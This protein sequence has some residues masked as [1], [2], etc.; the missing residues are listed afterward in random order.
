MEY[1]EFLKNK[2]PNEIDR[3]DLNVDDIH[4]A[5]FPFQQDC[6]KYL[7][8]LGRGAAFLSTGLGK[9]II[10]CEWARHIPGEVLIIAPL[11]VAHQT[12]A[13]A[14]KHLGMDIRYSKDGEVKGRVTI[15]NYERVENFDCERFT[16]VVLDESSILKG[17]TS[18][19][20]DMLI[21]RFLSTPY[22]LCCTATPAP[23]DYTELGQHAEFLGIMTKQ[24][25][26]SRW[27]VHDSANTAD[28]RIKKHAVKAFWNWVAS[29][30]A[31]V[32]HPRDLGYDDERYDLPPLRMHTHSVSCETHTA[33]EDGFLFEMG[34]VNAT[35]LHSKKRETVE[36]RVA[37]VAKM[38][39]KSD[40]PWLVWC[41]SNQ[42]SAMLSKAIGDCVEV[43]GS[44]SPDH[45]EKAL[46]DFAAGKIRVLVSKSSICGYG[47]NFQHCRKQVFASISYSFEKFYQAIRRSW[48]FG[49]D[50][51]VDVH[52]VIADAEIPVWRAVEKKSLDHE[53]L[54]EHMKYAV[55]TKGS[56]SNKLDYNPTHLTSIPSWLTS[57]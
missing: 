21:A 34:D 40:E 16:G 47:M 22:R 26:L 13:E 36:D 42:E 39:N 35:T 1:F 2:M 18:R 49:Q 54:H 17:V 48:R 5:L 25:M 30:S 45:K 50:R 52:V 43:K 31:C 51:P 20:R 9:T 4:Q 7:L 32:S 3:A 44:D 6:V 28:W 19:T 33:F 57:K 23:N 38:V 46:I 15:T 53:G 12:C 41:E 37:I 56:I 27:F 29:W 8:E 24:E 10:Q 55:F 11:A 14:K